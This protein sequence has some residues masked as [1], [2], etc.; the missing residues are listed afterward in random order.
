M[1]ARDTAGLAVF[2]AINVAVSALGGW[3]TASSVGTWYQGLAKP[4]FNPPDWV[5]APVWSALYLMI[6]VAGWRAWRRGGGEARRALVVYAVQLAL[7]LSWSFVFFGARLIGPAL[8]VIA[9]L[10][11]AIAANAALFWRLDRWAGA[12]LVPYAAWVSFAALLNAAL[13]R[14]N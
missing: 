2:L 8:L 3:A 7:N 9:A 12:L 13:W 5:F 10:L 6:A 11:A 4:A 1:R 14:L